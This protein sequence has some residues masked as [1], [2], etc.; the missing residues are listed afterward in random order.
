MNPT[1]I[2]ETTN[3]V[4]VQSDRWL[5]VALL[6]I[7]LLAVLL[8]ARYFTAQ[9]AKVQDQLTEVQSEFNGFLRNSNAELLTMLGKVTA[10]L[11]KLERK[12]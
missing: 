12:L 2:L 11:E 6:V 3:F 4:A 7:G 5:F 10:L 1:D 9:L 8:V